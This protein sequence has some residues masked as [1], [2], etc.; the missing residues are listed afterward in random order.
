MSA[1]SPSPADDRNGILII[2]AGLAGAAAAAV[3]GK[4]GFRVT[5]IDPRDACPPV[6]KAEKIELPQ[7]Q[8]A[9]KLGLLDPLLPGAGHIRE[10]LG[11]FN[12]RHVVTT[13]T[14]QYGMFYSDMTDIVRQCAPESVDFRQGRVVKIENGAELQRV[15][16][17][18]G[19][20]LT[21]R[22]IVLATGLNAELPASIGLTREMVRMHHSVAIAFTIARR[23]GSAFPFDALTCYS[24]G[25]HPGLDY[26][27]LFRIG[28]AMRANLFYFP[29]RE[30]PWLRDFLKAPER[31]LDACLP[32]LRQSM[33]DYVITERV[34][35]SQIHLYRSQVGAL[36][37]VVMIGDAAQNA[38][39][40]TGFG[41]SKVFTDV[42]LL[43]TKYVP[44]WLT[45]PGMGQDKLQAFFD[46]PRKRCTDQE[47]L[48]S[49]EYRRNA[50]T[51]RALRWRLHRAK[52]HWK[53]QF[54]KHRIEIDN[55]I[56]AWNEP[57]ADVGNK[58]CGT[59]MIPQ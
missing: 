2:G 57:T 35:S 40:S 43:C 38:C 18:S 13:R 34:E 56:G 33:N 52:L 36:P 24:M 45:T 1:R 28:K 10:I 51:G 54:G 7:A 15:Q 55:G 46:D 48:R 42:D 5:L 14:E 23:D 29:R 20:E 49:A 16:L 25:Q 19:E 6:F 58:T 9:R 50:C 17:D 8:I 4:S 53:M 39:P 32:R 47:A 30:D 27:T 59:E 41:L 3:L 31:R 26:L 37:G 44:Q 12:G 11:Y 21:S 22:L